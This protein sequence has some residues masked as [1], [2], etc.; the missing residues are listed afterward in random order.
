MY[1]LFPHSRDM[2]SDNASF[3]LSE[4]HLSLD[5]NEEKV[6]SICF[7]LPHHHSEFKKIGTNLVL[8]IL[9][10]VNQ[11]AVITCVLPTLRSHLIWTSAR[12]TSCQTL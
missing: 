3:T 2:G 8:G 6:V 7:F 10:L 11:S 4:V 5:E 9:A 12:L 1:Y